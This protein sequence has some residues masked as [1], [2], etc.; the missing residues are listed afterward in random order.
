[1][2]SILKRWYRYKYSGF[3]TVGS[4]A[5]LLLV[6]LFYQQDSVVFFNN[7]S[8]ETLINYVNGIDIPDRMIS[9]DELPATEHNTLHQFLDECEKYNRFSSPVN[10]LIDSSP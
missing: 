2:A 1:M 7:W 3:I 9:H 8:C 4:G 5:I 10:H 6:L